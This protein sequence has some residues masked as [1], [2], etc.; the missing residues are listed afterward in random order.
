MDGRGRYPQEVR[1]RAVRMVF[2]HQRGAPLTVG[3]DLLDRGEVRHDGG[4]A[5]GLAA[6]KG[7]SADSTSP[8]GSRASKRGGHR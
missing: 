4:D 1:E 2:D 7:G 5:S 8:V 6:G 3:S